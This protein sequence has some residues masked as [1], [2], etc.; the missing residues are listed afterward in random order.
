MAAAPSSSHAKPSAP[1]ASTAKASNST[2]AS[3]KAATPRS[4]TALVALDRLTVKGRA[5]LTGYSRDAFGPAWYD[6]NGNGCDTHNDVLRRDLHQVQAAGCTVRPPSSRCKQ[7]C[8][9][10][11]CRRWPY[12]PRLAEIACPGSQV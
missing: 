8:K 11:G 3:T 10:R 7:R 9:R 6:A 1:K 4:G 5:P 2:A 12:M